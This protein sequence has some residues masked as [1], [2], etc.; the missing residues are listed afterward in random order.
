MKIQL[1]ENEDLNRVLGVGYN[2]NGRNWTKLIVEHW[3]RLELED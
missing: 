1:E 2:Q 3:E